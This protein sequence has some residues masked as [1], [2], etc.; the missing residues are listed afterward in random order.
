MKKKGYTDFVVHDEAGNILRSG[1]CSWDTVPRQVQNNE[2]FVIRGKGDD[3]NHKV[4]DGKIVEKTAEEKELDRIPEPEPTPFSEQ[5]AG[6]TNRQLQDILSR[7]DKLE[8]G[9]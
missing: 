1:F 9:S 5:T 4:K 2:E 7:L 8:E 6:L 3:L